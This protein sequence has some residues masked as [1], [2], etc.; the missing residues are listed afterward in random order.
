[1]KSILIL[2]GF[3]GLALSDC[4]KTPLPP[5]ES[6]I[7]GGTEAK[8]Y[9]WPWQIVFCRHGWLGGCSLMCGGSVIDENWVMTAGHC[10]E[11][12]TNSPKS[13]RVK[14]GVFDQRKD[15][16]KGEVV[17]E[18]EKIF[19]HPKFE[20]V[21]GVPVYDVALLKL[22]SPVSFT[23][24]IQ[25]VCLPK[26]DAGL[27][28]SK[29]S[30]TITGWGTKEQGG[31]LTPSN[32]RQVVVPM[33]NQT[34]CDDAYGDQIFNPT[35][36]C[37]GLRGKDSCQGDSGGPLVMKHEDGRWFEYGVV[38]WG[39]GCAQNGYPGVYSRVTAYCD[40]LKQTVGKDM[41]Q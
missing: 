18:I 29:H 39:H 7:V 8:P 16:E 1:M 21:H 2:F 34:V 37:A 10:V 3:V 35:M 12:N 9:S 6:F 38:S 5:D 13:F 14:L 27:I 11:G 19:L 32:L 15:N 22:K 33:V 26:S 31:L 24:H 20:N 36:F 17:M 40:F 30:A 41:C 25:P 4:G 28:N 23:D